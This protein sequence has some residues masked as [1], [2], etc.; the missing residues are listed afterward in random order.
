MADQ[1]L[2]WPE[3]AS[4]KQKINALDIDNEEGIRTAFDQE[5]ADKLTKFK[6]RLDDIK[7]TYFAKLT[8]A[9]KLAKLQK[10]SHLKFR[11]NALAENLRDDLNLKYKM[12]ARMTEVL[13]QDFN[14]L[15]R[16]HA[17]EENVPW[18]RAGILKYCDMVMEK[19]WQR[20]GEMDQEMKTGLSAEGLSTEHRMKAQINV[21]PPAN[22]KQHIQLALIAVPGT[23]NGANPNTE[24]VLAI[25]VEVVAAVMRVEAVKSTDEINRLH[26]SIVE[27]IEENHASH[28][29][30]IILALNDRVTKQMEN[31]HATVNQEI[32]KILEPAAVSQSYSCIKLNLK[33]LDGIMECLDGLA[34]HVASTI[35]NEEKM[36]VDAIAPLSYVL[37][38]RYF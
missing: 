23:E 13:Q 15:Y 6:L 33:K 22:L 5:M 4:Y 18:V 30:D 34:D 17:V 38:N 11:Y 21:Y 7:A 19:F 37:A 10:N 25:G 9:Y 31:R 12:Q 28:D 14:V 29:W 1:Q 26:R 36:V 35:R 24:L 2:E 8:T 16:H 27:R 20:V 32:N 3:C